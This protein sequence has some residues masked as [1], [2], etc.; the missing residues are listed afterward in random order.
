MGLAGRINWTLHQSTNVGHEC[1]AQLGGVRPLRL[2]R[3]SLQSFLLGFGRTWSCGEGWPGVHTGEEGPS[4]SLQL[5]CCEL[6]EFYPFA[7]GTK[8]VTSEFL[9]LGER[10]WGNGEKW[11][12]S[13]LSDAGRKCCVK[14][15]ISCCAVG[16]WESVGKCPLR[17]A[18]LSKLPARVRPCGR[19]MGQGGG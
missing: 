10:I 17:A 9:L 14:V 19:K 4:S 2:A 11:T 7:S 15:P 13:P 8:P 5:L 18:T 6:G 1:R 12:A 16:K 3:V